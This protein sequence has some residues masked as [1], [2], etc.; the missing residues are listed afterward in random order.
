MVD[1]VFIIL[2]NG[3]VTRD[4]VEPGNDLLS[5]F[6]YLGS[7]HKTRSAELVAPKRG[8]PAYGQQRRTR[9]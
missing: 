7:P 6:S 3:K 2:T 4:D 9:T 1:F 5:R 8:R